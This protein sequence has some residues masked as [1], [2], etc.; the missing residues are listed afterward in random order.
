MRLLGAFLIIFVW[1]GQA[2][3]DVDPCAK[4]NCAK[5]FDDAPYCQVRDGKPVCVECA[6]NE[7][8]HDTG[9]CTMWGCVFKK[10]GYGKVVFRGQ[11]ISKHVATGGKVLIA[12]GWVHFSFTLLNVLFGVTPIGTETGAIAIFLPF[13]GAHLV[14][15]A[16]CL[17]YGYHYRHKKRTFG[18]ATHLSPFITPVPGG[19]MLGL[20]G[21]F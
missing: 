11:C 3:A 7:H 21:H 8:C 16:F 9:N 10:C 18:S 19:G 12:A 17:G 4:I 20:G 13:A 14:V 2:W 1:S 6:T 5:H 15:S